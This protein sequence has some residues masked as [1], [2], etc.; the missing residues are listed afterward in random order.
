M[1]NVSPLTIA[2]Q[3]FCRAK[4]FHRHGYLFKTFYRCGLP[5]TVERSTVMGFLN[6]SPLWVDKRF[7]VVGIR[8]APKNEKCSTP[9]TI[10]NVAPSWVFKTF[11]RCRLCEM[12][13]RH[14]FWYIPMTVEQPMTV[15]RFNTAC[16]FPQK[17]HHVETKHR[18][19]ARQNGK[20]VLNKP[21]TAERKSS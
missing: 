16:F 14:G 5:M 11:C 21:S 12:F 6:V 18:N 3:R 7:T 13:H 4:S 19:P 10:L 15:E 1:P 8:A 17:T 20:V 2:S 9:Q